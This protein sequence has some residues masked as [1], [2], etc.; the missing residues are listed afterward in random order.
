VTVDGARRDYGVV[1]VGDP[2]KRPEQVRVDGEATAELRARRR[3][4]EVTDAA[5]AGE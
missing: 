2:D 1:V 3:R 4:A 5:F